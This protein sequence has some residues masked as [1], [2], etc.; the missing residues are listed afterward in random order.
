MTP[1]LLSSAVLNAVAAHLEGLS[2]AQVVEDL[3]H[4]GISARRSHV[5]IYLNRH[6][7]T[8]SPELRD[9]RWHVVDRSAASAPTS[10]PYVASTRVL[11]LR[12]TP[13]RRRAPSVSQQ[14]IDQETNCARQRILRSRGALLGSQACLSRKGNDAATVAVTTA[15]DPP[16]PYI[17]P[18][19]IVSGRSG[20][21]EG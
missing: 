13:A 3:A 12:R 11:E 2:L 6:L 15:T 4:E 8:D 9:G 20:A 5:G 19:A 7:R 17:R 18:P 1:A 14:M 10:S 21:K 16:A